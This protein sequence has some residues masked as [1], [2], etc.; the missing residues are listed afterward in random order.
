VPPRKLWLLISDIQKAVKRLQKL[1]EGMALEKF[2]TDERTIEA[3]LYNFAIIGEAASKIPSAIRN[4][5]ATIPWQQMI[6][7]RNIVI[8]EYFRI[9]LEILWDTIQNRLPELLPSLQGMLVETQ[10][11]KPTSKQ[12][13]HKPKKPGR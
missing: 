6:G 10:Q 9:D 7:M 5:Q 11:E 12:Q 13:S 4:K 3:V 2:L 8:H 1:I